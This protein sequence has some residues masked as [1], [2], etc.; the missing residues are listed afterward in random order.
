L[1][2]TTIDAETITI[3]NPTTSDN[4][5]YKAKQ[6]AEK[7]T[8]TKHSFKSGQT[9]VD[10]VALIESTFPVNGPVVSD[11][12]ITNVTSLYINLDYNKNSLSGYSDNQIL[13][14]YKFYMD[15]G[16]SIFVKQKNC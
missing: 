16:F 5:F 1:N 6:Y 4:I 11:T 9:T 10:K 8:T 14:K 13:E 12:S 2:Q 7:D 3:T 15:Y